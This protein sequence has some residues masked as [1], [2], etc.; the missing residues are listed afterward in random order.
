MCVQVIIV[1]GQVIIGIG[2][3]PKEEPAVSMFQQWAQMHG[4]VVSTAY[5]T[6][7]QT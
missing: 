7:N 5:T 6:H 1:F 4:I 2:L 3:Q